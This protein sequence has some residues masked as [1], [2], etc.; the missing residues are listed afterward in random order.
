VREKEIMKIAVPAAAGIALVL[1]LVALGLGTTLLVLT[2]T[3]E[4]VAVTKF[5]TNFSAAF[6][7][8]GGL[9]ATIVGLPYVAWAIKTI[10][11]DVVQRRRNHNR[12]ANAG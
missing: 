5:N 8:L 9:F 11:I 1:G 10:I 6:G 2:S 7:Q 4:G 12:L 3:D